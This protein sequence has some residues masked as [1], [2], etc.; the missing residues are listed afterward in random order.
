ME[1]FFILWL[2]FAIGVGMLA[3]SRGRS[4]FGFFLLAAVLSPLI[5]LI[6]VLVMRDEKVAEET[7]S[8]RRRD[9][10]IRLEE[11]R[12]LAAAASRGTTAAATAPV[13]PPSPVQT[14][15]APAMFSVADEIRKLAELRDQGLLTAEEFNEQRRMLLGAGRST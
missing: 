7:E 11:V 2:L 9:E 14:F 1:G 6:V 13:H 8:R 4:G 12:A 3:S 15:K 5:G 10:E